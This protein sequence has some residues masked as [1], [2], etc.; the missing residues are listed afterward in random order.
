M[1]T[2]LEKAAKTS[3]LLEEEGYA[4]YMKAANGSKNSLGSA[5]LKAIADKELMHIKA[6]ENFYSQITG[7]DFD[8]AAGAADAQWSGRLKAEVLSGIKA[9]LEKSVAPD[10][11][12]MH[13]YE[14]GMDLE[15]KGYDFYK[16]IAGET[17]EPAAKKLFEF[18]AK[19]ESIHYD[20]LEDTHL[21]LSNPSEWFHKEEKWLVEG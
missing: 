6:I 18:L 16:K 3:I 10:K 15:K 20:L 5:T 9:S 7:K 11:E 19:E 14:V 13:A 17:E 12:L 2:D 21:Y 8:R 4:L 1:S